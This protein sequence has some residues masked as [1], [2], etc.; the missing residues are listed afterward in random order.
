VALPLLWQCCKASNSNTLQRPVYHLLLHRVSALRQQEC[1]TIF[2]S[3]HIQ[4]LHWY[5]LMRPAWP[6]AS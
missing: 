5:L 1:F 6:L 4:L 2:S 3:N